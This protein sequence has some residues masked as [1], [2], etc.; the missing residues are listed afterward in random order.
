MGIFDKIRGEF[1]DIIEWTDTRAAGSAA[2]FLIQGY[3]GQKPG[4]DFLN[5][6]IIVV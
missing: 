1:V 4:V 2:V 3:S 6:C 5:S